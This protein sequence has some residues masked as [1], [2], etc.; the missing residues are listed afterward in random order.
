M[1]YQN[2]SKWDIISNIASL[3]CTSTWSLFKYI[4]VFVFYSYFLLM[5]M[6]MLYSN[7]ITIFYSVWTPQQ[8]VFTIF[9]TISRNVTYSTIGRHWEKISYRMSYDKSL[10][11]I[12]T[13]E[14]S[15]FSSH[16]NNLSIKWDKKYWSWVSIQ[17]QSQYQRRIYSQID[18]V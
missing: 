1:H 12:G 4:S 2:I 8:R 7:A 10:K 18:N 9:Y 15:H 11:R 13:Y 6:S 3:S 5:S 17:F 14:S 16:N